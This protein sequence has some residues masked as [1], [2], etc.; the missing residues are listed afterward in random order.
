ML[1]D[2][3]RWSNLANGALKSQWLQEVF[4]SGLF[5]LDQAGRCVNGYDIVVYESALTAVLRFFCSFLRWASEGPQWVELATELWDT[6]STNIG[7][8]NNNQQRLTTLIT[9][10]VQL[11][12]RCAENPRAST[13]G[14]VA[15][16]LRPMLIGPKE[17]EAKTLLRD[18]LA[19]LPPPFSK[20]PMES[21]RIIQ[22]LSIN[23]TDQRR[24]HKHLYDL[25]EEFH[26]ALKRAGS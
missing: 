19:Q 14:G 5:I 20:N 24:F 16:V 22:E 4:D 18:R 26:G 15:E 21:S 23:K 1:G 11:L 6:C 17:F 9:A 2:A 10:L 7:A 25:V 13:I 8:S 3:L 12:V